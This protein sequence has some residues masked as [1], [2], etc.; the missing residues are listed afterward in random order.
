M[1]VRTGEP[2]L[3][4]DQVPIRLPDPLARLLA[5]FADRPRPPGWAA[6]HPNHW[7]FPSTEPGRHITGAALVRRLTAHGI[8]SRPARAAAL[9]QLAQD[10]P[11]AV[12]A[13][14]L[15]LNLITLTRWRARAATDWT[16]YLQARTSNRAATHRGSATAPAGVNPDGGSPTTG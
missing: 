16:A 2:V 7:L 15:G 12:L 4:L 10:M 9:V 1:T 8:P 6:N 14:M 3:V 13:P 11:S 5:D